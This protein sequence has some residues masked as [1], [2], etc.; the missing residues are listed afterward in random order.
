MSA[1]P[2]HHLNKKEKDF[3]FSQLFDRNCVGDISFILNVTCHVND[4]LY[5]NILETVI[6]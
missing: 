2:F 4:S 1:K 5:V 3:L 6:L